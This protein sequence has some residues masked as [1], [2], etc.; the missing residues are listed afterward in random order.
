MI[1]KWSI[2]ILMSVLLFGVIISFGKLKTYSF[3]YNCRNGYISEVIT[4]SG[5]NVEFGITDANYIMDEDGKGIIEI[6]AVID[7]KDIDKEK[8]HKYIELGYKFKSHDDGVKYVKLSDM[9]STPSAT[10]D[11]R[12]WIHNNDIGHVQLSIKE[13]FDINSVDI[14][15][16]VVSITENKYTLNETKYEI[17]IPLDKVEI[18]EDLTAFNKEKF[19]EYYN[20]IN[21]SYSKNQLL[22]VEVKDFMLE[23]Y[24]F[25]GQAEIKNVS[26][27]DLENLEI[28]LAFLL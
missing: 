24:D 26:D 10:E 8:H 18:Q 6:L 14:E 5:G 20:K 27:Y 13:E 19:D 28:F 16:F 3:N 23:G 12:I 11:W 17:E 15:S 22:T 1:K 7:T 4:I 25:I 2:L 9:V 21:S